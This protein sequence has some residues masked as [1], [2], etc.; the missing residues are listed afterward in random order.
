[1]SGEDNEH[2]SKNKLGLC[3]ADEKEAEDE[4]GQV[5]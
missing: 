5:A 3:L 2:S 4:E 1:M